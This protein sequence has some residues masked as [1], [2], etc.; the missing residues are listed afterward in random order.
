MARVSV[1]KP[2]SGRNGRWG[3]GTADGREKNQ[4]EGIKSGKP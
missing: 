4:V 1:D 2:E 3:V